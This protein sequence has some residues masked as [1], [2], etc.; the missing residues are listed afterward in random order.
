MKLILFPTYGGIKMCSTE[1]SHQITG[2]TKQAIEIANIKS[3]ISSD[4]K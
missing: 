2:H 1:I 4:E 3:F